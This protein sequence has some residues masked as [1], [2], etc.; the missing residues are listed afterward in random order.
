MIYLAY[1]DNGPS[2]PCGQSMNTTSN[3]QRLY[4]FNTY[5]EFQKFIEKV[6]TNPNKCGRKRAEFFGPWTDDPNDGTLLNE[7]TNL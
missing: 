5:S 4:R 7:V 2:G 1:K 3:W 6:D